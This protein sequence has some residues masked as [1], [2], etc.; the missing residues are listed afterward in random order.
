MWTDEATFTRGG[1]INHRN[2]HVWAH[3]NPRTVREYRFQH[4]FTRSPDLTP[5]N[6]IFV[7]VIIFRLYYLKRTRILVETL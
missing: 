5:N 6:G 3:E 4:E 1:I 7:F 2:S